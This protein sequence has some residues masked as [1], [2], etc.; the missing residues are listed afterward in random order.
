MIFTSLIPKSIDFF[1]TI[2]LIF[3]LKNWNFFG[4]IFLK[5]KIPPIF[6]T[7]LFLGWKIRHIFDITKLKR[8]FVQ[9]SKAI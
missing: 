7:F 8:N 2:F 4:Y 1:Q 3:D 6:A 5:V 9:I